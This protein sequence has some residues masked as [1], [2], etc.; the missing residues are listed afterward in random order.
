[1]TALSLNQALQTSDE[2]SRL[3]LN[4]VTALANEVA[5]ILPAGNVVKMVFSQLRSIKGRRIQADD[6]RRMLGSLQQGMATFLDKA[7]YMTFYT[8]PAILISGYQ[9]LLRAAGRDPLAAFPNGT[10]QFYLE[11]G[12]REDTARH[13][14]ETVGFQQ[15][16]LNETL[17]VSEADQLAAWILAISYLLSTYHQLL[18][19]EWHER[20]L[21]KRIGERT[22]DK[23]LTARWVAK[24]PYSVP[25]SYQQDYINHRRGV[26]SEF[27]R[28]HVSL[29]MR[30]GQAN[31]TSQ[32]WHDEETL[33]DDE[34]VAY[35]EQMT[36][37]TTL[38]PGAFN[39]TRLP[40][41]WHD[42]SIAVIWQNQYHIIPLMHNGVLLDVRAIRALAHAIL[43]MPAASQSQPTLDELLIDIPRAG[44]RNARL[45]LPDTTLQ[46]LNS[47]R[48]SPVILNW[49]VAD[50]G[51]P[52]VQIRHRRRGIGDHALTVFRTTDSIVF[53]QSHIFFDA[54][55]GM[56]VAEILTNQAVAYARSMAGLPALTGT[57]IR[58]RVLDMSVLPK[59]VRALRALAAPIAEIGAETE[60][61][62]VTEINVL[63]RAL[64]QRSDELQLTV[65]DFL[66]L[67]R[68]LYNQWYRPSRRLSSTLNGLERMGKR[69]QE[70][71]QA[72]RT[73]IE[74]TR[75]LSPAFLIPIDASAQNPRARI[76]PVT[77]CPRPPWTDIGNEHKKTWKL[78]A[79]Y[80]ETYDDEHWR[81][82]YD[83][84]TR[85]LAMLRMFGLLLERYK[86]IALEG[87]S[88]STAT[89][90][91]LGGIPKSLQAILSNIP[92][93]IDILND[94]L[95]G[96]EVFSNVG[97]VSDTSSLW[98]FITAKDDN[99]RKE[100]CWGI[101]TRA[102]GTMVISLRDFRPQVTALLALDTSVAQLVTYDFLEGYA[103]GLR[104][105]ITEL[106][107]IVEMRRKRKK[108]T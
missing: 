71:V 10:W 78:L 45:Q 81:A 27:V 105:Y 74:A 5:R 77:F 12:L 56:A 11:F 38:E 17:A 4:D 108:S 1:M 40:L 76:F 86:Q 58:P 46:Q 57:T 97:R 34:R 33:A 102:D 89:L 92:D 100:L 55:W 70:A 7:A 79:R 66:I 99:Q 54:I 31:E 63:R 28:E 82:F 61:P 21:L 19:Q 48:S 39:D 83:A 6:T 85:Y 93:K 73:M 36:L 72:V 15:T 68:S 47:L 69:Q 43:A 60:V 44:Q 51:L 3:H 65:N 59:T 52:L 101:M 13:A 62:V 16:I 75:N 32:L 64:S 87:K 26:F 14:C 22:G 29:F 23:R 90:E 42:C 106:T 104:E 80:R 30:P 9:L 67:Y 88:F 91:I 53:D 24:R 37:L 94:M 35:Q 2:L 107:E 8:T 84:R 20:L 50:A 96:T 18:A 25:V 49:D 95:K 103:Q 98:R 41:N